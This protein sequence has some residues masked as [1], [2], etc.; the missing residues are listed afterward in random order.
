MTGPGGVLEPHTD[1]H[2]YDGL[3][4]FRQVNAL[5]Y[6]NPVWD[7]Q[8][9]GCLELFAH[10]NDEEP[11]Q[12]IL[13]SWGTLV[14]F[15]TDDRSF[16]GF[17]RPVAEGHWRRS[18]AT[19]YYTAQERESYHGDAATYWMPRAATS[20]PLVR[21][22]LAAY[23]ALVAGQRMIAHAAAKARPSEPPTVITPPLRDRRL[24]TQR[25]DPHPD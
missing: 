9:G 10:G 12:R 1:F 18:I 25:D 16:H 4:L 20:S 14:V 3:G 21:T 22:R 17:P 15:R 6:L 19:Y 2:V 11:A 24:A 13:P 5:L 23:R 7:E 8:W